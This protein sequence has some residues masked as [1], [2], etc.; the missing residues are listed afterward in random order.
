MHNPVLHPNSNQCLHC[1]Q[2]DVIPPTEK[3]KERPLA[4]PNTESLESSRAHSRVTQETEP[5]PLASAFGTLPSPE[6]VA[7]EVARTQVELA[8]L[9]ASLG[10]DET[11]LDTAQDAAKDAAAT[12]PVKGGRGRGRGRNKTKK[13]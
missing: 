3:R 2:Q 7:E 12:E 5:I 10:E 13:K 6:V 11:V 8:S 4:S 9:Q 1:D